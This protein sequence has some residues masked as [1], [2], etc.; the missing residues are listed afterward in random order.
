MTHH[1]HHEHG[2]N[3]AEAM[4]GAN[5]EP[6]TEHVEHPADA[7]TLTQAAKATGAHRSA[8]R[9]A[10]DKEKFPN[11]FQ[12]SDGDQGESAVWRIPVGDLLA[13]G[14]PVQVGGGSPV[15]AN[16]ATSVID[17]REDPDPGSAASVS[18][19]EASRAL[20][21]LDGWRGSLH[22]LANSLAAASESAGRAEA[23]LEMTRERLAEVRGERDRLAAELEMARRPTRRGWWFG[24]HGTSIEFAHPAALCSEPST[25]D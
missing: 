21:V 7:L 15:E 18:P 12:H 11:A 10:L 2:L 19:D 14:Y 3:R 17:L 25:A 22:D 6:A 5:T 8:I 20:V 23:K 16:S 1:G 24:R 4:T 9:R 13:A